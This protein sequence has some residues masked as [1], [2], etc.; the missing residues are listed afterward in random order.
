MSIE[1][2]A[3]LLSSWGGVGGSSHK[4]MNAE[5]S[6]R[7]PTLSMGTIGISRRT[8]SPVEGYG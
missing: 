7:I 6:I 1:T 5:R 4:E 3:H 2:R 8:L